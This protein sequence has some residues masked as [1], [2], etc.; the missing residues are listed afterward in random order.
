MNTNKFNVV[1]YHCESA[2]GLDN[3][4]MLNNIGLLKNSTCAILAKHAKF[5]LNDYIAI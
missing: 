2:K 1:I 4:E 5:D 3:A